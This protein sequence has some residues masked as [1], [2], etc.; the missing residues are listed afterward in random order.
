MYIFTLL[1]L[2]YYTFIVLVTFFPFIG[3]EL[4]NKSNKKKIE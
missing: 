1:F 3:I 4:D 2:I